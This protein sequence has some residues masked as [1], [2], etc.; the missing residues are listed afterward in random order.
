[1]RRDHPLFE[2]DEAGAGAAPP[3]ETDQRKLEGSQPRI[4][5]E[6]PWM[7]LI[8][9][10]WRR[11][12]RSRPVRQHERLRSVYTRLRVI[13]DADARPA[14][15]RRVRKI[16]RVIALGRRELELLHA[17]REIFRRLVAAERSQV[18]ERDR[19]LACIR[20]LEL[21]IVGLSELMTACLAFVSS[22]PSRA[23]A[24]SAA[25]RVA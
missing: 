11:A 22:I 2:Q 3:R 7:L 5:Q 9:E 16:R 25:I 17:E 21:D 24:P 6:G 14:S 18:P 8:N 10:T 20:A 1:L 19:A 4:E 23:P 13:A 12:R 15:R